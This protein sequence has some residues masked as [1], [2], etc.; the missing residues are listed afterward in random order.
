VLPYLPVVS[1][2]ARASVAVPYWSELVAPR[3]ALREGDPRRLKFMT[4]NIH[5]GVG[6]D[7]RYDLGR[8]RRVLNDERP[9]IVSMLSFSRGRRAAGARIVQAGTDVAFAA[10]EWS[11]RHTQGV[12]TPNIVQ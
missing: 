1:L 3:H 6:I 9:H 4:Y 2:S 10:S 11:D 5:S 8:I 12:H 7:R